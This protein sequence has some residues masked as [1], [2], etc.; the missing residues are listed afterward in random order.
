M[1]TAQKF[2]GDKDCKIE[3]LKGQILERDTSLRKIVEEINQKIDALNRRILELDE[4]TRQV[5][6]ESKMIQAWSV[7]GRSIGEPGIWGNGRL[8]I[9]FDPQSGSTTEHVVVIAKALRRLIRGITIR[10]FMFLPIRAARR[11]YRKQKKM[12]QELSKG[13]L[14]S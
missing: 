4:A 8:S 7:P 14:R 13:L 11:R 12:A 6:S 2:S 1:R 10:Q 3:E 9:S 5:S